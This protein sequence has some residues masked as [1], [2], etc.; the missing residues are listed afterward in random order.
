MP[1]PAGT[2]VVPP[3]HA[4]PKR[5]CLGCVPALRGPGWFPCGPLPPTP[6]CPGS[7][8]PSLGQEPRSRPGWGPPPSEIS[9]QC[10]VPQLHSLSN[11]HCILWT[12][13]FGAGVSPPHGWPCL[14]LSPR[15]EGREGGSVL[16][17]GT[18]PG[19]GRQSLGRHAPGTW[20]PTGTPAGAD[21]PTFISL[22][23]QPYRP[24]GTQ[25]RSLSV[26]LDLC[27][28]APPGH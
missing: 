10:P 23:P 27:P 19:R 5:C 9:A 15:E 1:L 16:H 12:V 26:A 14:T 13:S 2:V 6:F 4:L 28:P 17:G 22:P 25:M 18:G 20:A 7:H 8:T 11:C 24:Q 3:R 21:P